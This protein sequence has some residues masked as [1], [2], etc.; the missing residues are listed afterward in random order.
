MRCQNRF[1]GESD[2]VTVTIGDA[3]T[4]CY[5]LNVP[6]VAEAPVHVSYELRQ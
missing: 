5:V 4:F 3:R 1:W 2:T 6:F